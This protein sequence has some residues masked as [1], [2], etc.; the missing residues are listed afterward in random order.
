[1]IVFDLR[2]ANEHV[3]EAW[4]A[5]SSAYLDQQESGRVRC[6]LCD[7]PDVEKAAMAPNIGT[8][9]NQAIGTTRP[10][11]KQMLHALASIQAKMLEKSEWVGRSF[12][13][14]ARAMHAGEEDHSTIHGQATPAE[15]QALADEGVPIAPLPLPVTPPETL[16]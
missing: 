6:P 14:R 15:A 10:G 9:G 13:T 1:M 7:S 4:F 5:S 16:N 8:K 2:C 11:A 12:A 3:F